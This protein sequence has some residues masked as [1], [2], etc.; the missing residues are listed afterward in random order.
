MLSQYVNSAWNFM[1]SLTWK[2][3]RYKHRFLALRCLRLGI[4]A[5]IDVTLQHHSIE[6]KKLIVPGSGVTVMVATAAARRGSG[7]GAVGAHIMVTVAIVVAAARVLL[8]YARR[9][10][11]R[12][13]CRGAM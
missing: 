1:G 2:L 5:M 7:T 6:Q 8:L 12:G 10:A 11:A 9:G 3:L 13:G 4:I